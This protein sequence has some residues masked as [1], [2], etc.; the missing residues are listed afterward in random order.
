M[1]E[2]D[3]KAAQTALTA[4][5][6]SPG[7]STLPLDGLVLTLVPREEGL[8]P[9]EVPVDALF[10]KLTMM[11]DKLRVL[12][13]RLNAA[14]GLALAER[15]ELQARVTAVYAAFTGLAAFFSA[16]A[17][18]ATEGSDDARGGGA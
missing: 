5:G 7:A 4:L 12:E 18:P 17:L 15:A 13:Q 9:K 6:L 1:S 14:D 3:A 10:H 11:R 8:A 16:E 2:I